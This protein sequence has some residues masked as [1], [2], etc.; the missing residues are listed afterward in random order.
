MEA[1]LRTSSYLIPV[2]LESEPDKYMLIH[3]YTGAIDIA[4][5]S[6]LKKIQSVASDTDLLPEMVE[7]LLKRGYITTKTQEEEYAYVARMAKALHKESEILHTIFTWVVTYNCNFR[8]PYCFEG[9]ENKDGTRKIVFTK[10]MVDCAYQTM[11]KIQPHKELRNNIITLYGGEPLLAENKDIV[12]YIVEEGVKRGYS[13]VAV[14]NGYEVDAFLDLLSPD[15]I[16]KLQITID[17]PKDMHNQRRIHY[18]GYE[19]FDKIISNIQLALERDVKVTVRM[20]TDSNNVDKFLELKSYFE[21]Q[22]FMNYPKFSIYSALL[23]DNDSITLSEHQN[24]NFLSVGTFVDKQKEWEWAKQ[25]QDYGLYK[26]IYKALSEK[27]FI[28][29]KS[30]GCA[31]QAGG[32]VLDPLGNIYPCWEVIGNKE[33]CKGRYNFDGITWNDSVLT[34]WNHTDISQKNPCRHCKYALMCGGGCP[35]YHMLGNS[36]QCAFFQKMFGMA[37]NYAYSTFKYNNN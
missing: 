11:D 26:S 19:T 12:T 30:I 23:K 18:A 13:F 28:Q 22:G 32:Y 20:N 25:G 15:K 34:Q 21:N 36:R 9:R 24:L 6:L 7:V 33:Y 27:R 14:T 17:G 3:G 8:C 2:K 29:F 31:A 35:Y 10:E 5:E 1:P 37:V 4:T 16:R